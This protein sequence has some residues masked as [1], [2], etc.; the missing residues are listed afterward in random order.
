M[1]Y[2]IA[3]LIQKEVLQVGRDRVLIAV[4]ILGPALQLSLLAWNTGR[5][6]TNL[7]LAVLDQDH[8]AI[9]RSIITALD[10]TKELF[11]SAY[12]SDAAQL[13]DWL[14]GGDAEIGVTIPAGFERDLR[15]GKGDPQ[16]QVI[17]VGANTISGKVALG[18]AQ[19]AVGIAIAGILA[20]AGLP[21]PAIDLRVDVRYNPA[22]D[23]RNYTLPAMIGLIV[24]ELTLILASLG[25]TRERETGTLEQLIIM[26]F[27][28]FEIVAGKA[29][30]PLIIALA[31]FGLMLVIATRVFGV[32]LRG[33]LALLFGLTAL[34]ML[35]E[36]GW[37]LLL[38]TLARTQQQAVLFVF[39]QAIFDMTFSGFL[40]PVENLP[41]ALG[42]F[43]NIIPLRHYLVII[44]TIMLKGA[45]LDTLLPEAA[46]LA[47]LAAGIW[48][49]A[50]MNLGRRI[51]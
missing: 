22:L 18:A 21:D 9:S 29:V 13:S 43:S 5:G 26:P 47:L 4:L 51:D 50:V 8:T 25:L 11:L 44:R 42:V 48:A 31:D 12:A 15:G 16:L 14:A 6:V 7:P 1:W 41:P 49:I 30:A 35:A 20:P 45:A 40:V 19:R 10:S 3:N 28:R 2:R 46:I 36:I 27:R 34:F 33:S 37:G 24:F 23:T 17:A 39:V 38:S 32:P